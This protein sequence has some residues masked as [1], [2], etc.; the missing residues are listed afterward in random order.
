MPIDALC[1]TDGAPFGK[2]PVRA[3]VSPDPGLQLLNPFSANLP[4]SM[5]GVGPLRDPLLSRRNGHAR[6]LVQHHVLRVWCW[7]CVDDKAAR[8]LLNPASKLSVG[9]GLNHLL[10]LGEELVDQI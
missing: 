6:R 3:S 7:P 5:L 2:R 8:V 9:L 1:S 4:V 10:L